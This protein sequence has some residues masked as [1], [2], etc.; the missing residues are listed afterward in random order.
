MKVPVSEA[1]PSEFSFLESEYGFSTMEVTADSVIY[2]RGAYEIA[3]SCDPRYGEVELVL[4]SVP[5]ANGER[6]VSLSLEELGRLRP[7]HTASST[8]SYPRGSAEFVNT[9]IHLAD[10]LRRLAAPFLEGDEQWLA[11]AYED[12]LT[13]N[14][15]RMQEQEQ[16]RRYE[17]A[18]DALRRGDYARTIAELGDG[19]SMLSPKS[20]QLLRFAQE[21]IERRA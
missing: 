6:I 2:C 4:R 17:T 13:R 1:V 19:E 18:R 16:Q 5:N 20:L 8:I 7:A 11:S 3:V 10:E 15:T 21:Q 12:V 9:V 14:R